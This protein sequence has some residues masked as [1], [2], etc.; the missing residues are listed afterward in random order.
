MIW[1]G[2]QES[3]FCERSEDLQNSPPVVYVT[4]SSE[5]SVAVEALKAGAVDFVVKTVGPN[6]EV[7]LLAALEQSLERAKQLREKERAETES[8]KN[9]TA[10]WRFWMRSITASPTVLR[11]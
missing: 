10:R 4:A 2:R 7:Q 5:L 3:T 1:A 9:A 11:W 6:F 8:A